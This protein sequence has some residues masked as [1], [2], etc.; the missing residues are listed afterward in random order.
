MDD[1]TSIFGTKENFDK[2]E[3]ELNN[4]VSLTNNT[5]IQVPNQN[6]VKQF[7]QANQSSINNQMYVEPKMPE[8]MYKTYV[9]PQMNLASE[10]QK[11]ARGALESKMPTIATGVASAY[12]Y[13]SVQTQIEEYEEQK[14]EE[15][16]KIIEP[17]MPE[18]IDYKLEA[19][20]RNYFQN[21]YEK[22]RK[23]P[24][25]FS[26]FFFGGIYFFYRKM[27][28]W[29][30]LAIALTI[31]TSAL[32][33]SY[34]PAIILE[35]IYGFIFNPLY[36]YLARI[37]IK[38]IRENNTA[39]NL[40]LDCTKKGGT[41]NEINAIMLALV[42]SLI[43]LFLT[44]YIYHKDIIEDFLGEK[45]DIEKE[46]M[47]LTANSFLDSLQL[48][49]LKTNSNIN[50]DVLLPKAANGKNVS[51]TL[52]EGSEEFE[53]TNGYKFTKTS[54]TCKDFMKK[55]YE[56]NN[57]IE[58]PISALLI[59]DNTGTLLDSSRLNYEKYNCTYNIALESFEC[60]KK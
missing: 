14:K 53:N 46:N 55:V 8:P 12:D 31:F 32:F 17:K 60:L 38:L 37:D 11:I 29:G 40:G 54:S 34:I 45:K 21:N 3:I 23:N 41:I 33:N 18:V 35:I 9:E 4:N 16:K 52:K 30:V 24:F 20:E 5:N 49:I 57:I 1:N 47:E 6:P 28:F 19:L 51:C 13:E 22:L 10:D 42:T 27:Y 44:T 39:I 15:E 50:S 2:K 26:A 25:N 59:F 36:R 7:E 48:Y 58:K 56:E 43:C